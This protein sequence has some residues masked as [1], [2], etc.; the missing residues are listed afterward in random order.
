MKIKLEPIE[1]NIILSFLSM[2]Q[3]MAMDEGDRKQKKYAKRLVNKFQGDVDEVDVK[4]AEL[5]DITKIL[6]SV[7][8]FTDVDREVKEGELP[9]MSKEDYEICKNIHEKLEALC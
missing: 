7:I 5:K 3:G 1:K 4:K 9:P 2:A 8:E 6:E